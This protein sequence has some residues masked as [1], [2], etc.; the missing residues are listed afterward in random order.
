MNI[1][2]CGFMG[3]GKTVVGRE[4][5]KITGRKFVDTDELIEKEQGV[6]IA[7]IFAAHGEDYFRDLEHEMCKKV[8]EM[9]NAVVST[10]GG[11]MTFE[12]NVESI[13][14]NGKVVFLDASFDVIC[15]RVGNGA[16]RPLFKDKENARRLY[17][18]RREKYLKA[19]D[20]V[21]N[22]DNS[23]RMTA[24]EIAQMVK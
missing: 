20:I 4:L 16:T 13:K 6:A 23:A 8:S 14:K 5:A 17:D 1:I 11:A 3:A 19:S 12:R 18:E 15:E 10:G 24:L 2:L 9:K 21:V 7:A 22:G